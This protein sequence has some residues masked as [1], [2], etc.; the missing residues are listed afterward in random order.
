MNNYLERASYTWSDDSIRFINTPSASA[1][2]N[3]FYVQEIGYFKTTPPYFTER[4][5]LSSY[6]IVYTLSGKGILSYGDTQYTI[7][8]GQLFF[9]H[10][11]P[12]HHYACA[13]DSE[14]EFLWLHFNGSSAGGFYEEFVKEQFSIVHCRDS[15]TTESTLRRILS[16]TIK[17]EIH[18]EILCSNLITNILTDLII[19]NTEHNLALTFLPDYIKKASKELEQHFLEPFSLE[20]IA[21]SCGVSKYHLS[22]EFKK[23]IGIPPNEYV[24]SLRLNYAKELLRFSRHSITEIS[25]QCGFNQTSHFIHLFKEREGTTPL[26]YRKEWTGS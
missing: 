18:S 13:P 12:F 6:L 22:R 14:W 7:L 4:K 8:P 26:Q 11:I 9:I 15:F 23:Y 3:F 17:K 16:L 2:K 10:C 21:H 24:I 5:N 19:Q 1:R 25:E 20:K